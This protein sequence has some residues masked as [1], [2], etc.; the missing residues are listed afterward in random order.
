MSAAQ[1]D[2]IVVGGGSAGC[3]VAG[4]LARERSTRVALVE[5]GESADAHPE[6]L[7][8]DGYKDA[9]NND[10]LVLERFSAP[11]R[12]S[13]GRRIFMGTGKGLGGSGSI[14]GMV[15]T[16]GARQDYAEWPEGF[17]YDDCVPAFE[18]LEKALRVRSRAP[19]RF[20]ETFVAA[21]VEAGFR[22]SSDLNSGDLSGVIGYETMNY[23]GDAR[24]SSY[25]AFVRDAGLR[26]NLDVLL[27]T[28]ALR[29]VFNRKRAIGVE[30]EQ[31]GQRRVLQARAE[32]VL[33][34]GALE[35]PKLL[36]LSGIGPAPQLAKHGVEIVHAS[37]EVG[38]NLHDHP[39]VPLFF[40]G[41]APVDVA[42]PQLYAFHRANPHSDL[43]RGQSDTCY[44]MYPARSSLREAAMRMLPTK[45]PQ[46]LYGEASKSL[47]RRGIALATRFDV[48]QRFIERTWGVVVILGKPKSR[49]V[50]QLSSGDPLQPA[51]IDPAY[52]DHPEDLDTMLHGVALAR[53]IANAAPLAAWGNEALMPSRSLSGEQELKAFVRDNAISTFHFVGTC[54]LGTDANAV[55]DPS[56]RVRG[57]EG[58]RV[59]DASLVPSA[60]VSAL[61][62]PSMMLGYRAAEVLAQSRRASAERE[63][64]WQP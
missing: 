36:L 10:A 26:D 16:R 8:A 30:V 40:R 62:A 57:V 58:L 42:Y 1:Y 15:Y 13:S 14:N 48:T 44:V 64:S 31:A 61:N 24:R 5:L 19:T 45:L 35:T 46:S 53:R 47:I 32:V 9:F 43:P 17:R 6:T 28:R 18:A 3:I 2:Y 20:T 50:L 63:A 38:R 11:Q 39:N 29:V 60:P 4:M 55:V 41:R 37:N 12:N 33:C 56:F 52:F 22:R 27:Q 51:D 49:G 23:E 59:A 34:L 25:V 21:A 54:R 7:R